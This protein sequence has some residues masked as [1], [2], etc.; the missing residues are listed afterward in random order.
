[1]ICKT[2]VVDVIYR[3]PAFGFHTKYG[4]SLYGTAMHVNSGY[5][6]GIDCVGHEVSVETRTYTADRVREKLCEEF[7]RKYNPKVSSLMYSLITD[8]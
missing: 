7:L 4:F 2:T 6:I 5:R 1:M 8:R 3:F